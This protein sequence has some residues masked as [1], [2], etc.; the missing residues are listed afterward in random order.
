M[1][2]R[3]RELLRRRKRF[4]DLRARHRK[5]LLRDLGELLSASG[6]LASLRK[7]PI[8]KQSE[9]Q[10]KIEFVGRGTF[11]KVLS[12]GFRITARKS[13]RGKGTAG[14]FFHQRSVPTRESYQ[15]ARPFVYIVKA[16][17][18]AAEDR[19]RTPGRQRLRQ[20]GLDFG[21]SHRGIFI[22]FMLNFDR[23]IA[24]TI[25]EML[26]KRSLLATVLFAVTAVAQSLAADTPGVTATEIKIGTQ[27]PIAAPPQLT[28]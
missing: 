20:D 7:E 6:N 21:C 23:Q 4:F 27:V 26:E 8:N 22:E 19:Y 11:R 17:Q 25:R 10:L 9:I 24:I 15:I 12:L 13:V 1:Q 28:P 14:V 3:H 18:L 5:G 2:A 16:G